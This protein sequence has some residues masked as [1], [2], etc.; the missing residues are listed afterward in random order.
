ME[1][2]LNGWKVIRYEN[3][4]IDDIRWLEAAK[5]T[6]DILPNR[7]GEGRDVLYVFKFKDVEHGIF[8]RIDLRDR[9]G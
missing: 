6:F 2:I 8:P 7:D 4:T 5:E 1:Y 3:Y 9:K